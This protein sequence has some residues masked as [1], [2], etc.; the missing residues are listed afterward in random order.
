[1][2]WVDGINV[3]NIPLLFYSSWNYQKIILQSSDRIRIVSSKYVHT[4][5]CVICCHYR[6]CRCYDY[7]CPTT[8]LQWGLM[9]SVVSVRHSVQGRGSRVIIAHN[10][11][12]ITVQ[13]PQLCPLDMRSQ[14]TGIP[15]PPTNVIWWPKLET[16]STVQTYSPE[17]PVEYWV[18]SNETNTDVHM[19]T[20]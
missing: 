18:I 4:D 11:L 6:C 8:K 7:Y 9:F 5:S 19:Y 13:F 14:C 12:Y 20:L 1:M 17:N 3:R 15:Q 10:A 2:L 16:C